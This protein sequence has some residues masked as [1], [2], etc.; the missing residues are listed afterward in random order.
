[1]ALAVAPENIK[2]YRILRKLGEG[3]MGVVYA[4]HD[5]RL[6]RHV[7]IKM[8]RECT[9]DESAQRRFWREARAAAGV[10][11]PNVCQIHDIGE[12]NGRPFIVMELLEG[13]SLAERLDRG[14]F[15]AA[16]AIAVMLGLLAALEALHRREIVHR[17]LKPS[18]VFL[19]AHGPKVLDFGLACAFHP[20]ATE[21]HV[22]TITAL[23][24]TGVFLGTPHYA[25]PE[26]LQGHPV[27]RPSDLFSAV[28]ILFEMLTGKR[29]FP[30]ESAIA[31]FHAVMYQP[32]PTLGN[33]PSL[34]PLDPIIRRGL[35]RR[36]EERYP[37]AVEMALEIR[38][39]SLQPELSV[40]PPVRRMERL[41]V[42]PFRILRPDADTDFL[43]FSLPDAIGASISGLGSLIV[44]SSLTASRFAGSSPDLKAIATEAQVDVV[45]TGTLLRAG[46]QIR[47]STQLVEVPSGTLIWSQTAQVT[48][49]DIFQLQDDLVHGM[50]DALS[51]SL[52]AHEHRMLKRDVPA[53]ATAYEFYLRAN[54]VAQDYAN[55][56]IARDLYSRCVELDQRYAP[57]WARLGRCH[58]IL[59]KWGEDP[60]THFPR[61]EEAFRRAFELNPDL[62]LAHNLHARL[63]ADRG[64]ACQGMSSLLRRAQVAG[65][66]PDLFVGLVHLCRYCGLLEASLAA[67][68]RA[69]RI[70]PLIRTSVAHTHFMM[71]NYPRVLETAGVD[72]I[73]VGPIT[74]ALMG[75][76]SESVAMAREAELRMP[77]S[78]LLRDLLIAQRAMLEGR[79]NEGLQALERLLAKRFHDLEGSYYWARNLARLEEPRRALEVLGE[80]VDQGYCCFPVMERDP[81]IEPLRAAPEFGAILRRAEQ[82]HQEAIRIFLEAGGESVLGLPA[83]RPRR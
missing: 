65:N 27:G 30:G 33:S 53:S 4:A 22:S 45:L 46:E 60:E 67:H 38:A 40:D 52:T 64:R 17:D 78:E 41:M 50:V 5:E 62:S 9:A 56:E 82:C 80:T 23:T 6:H 57:A 3:G 16:D 83:P 77:A 55:V 59:A 61:A 18:N 54:Q 48:L 74:L 36:P 35:A 51:L 75:R 70:D 24:L 25:S 31:A 19:T 12:E 11:H 37:S 10:N 69:Q 42:L 79:R 8:I 34:A 44:R 14:R 58:W 1:M 15:S 28:A 21:T 63:E 72:L 68:K 13:E 76:D 66:D 2:H 26:Q 39:V 43:A 71:G 7:A 47:V 20:T 49:R 32:L 81:W 73:Y 29:A